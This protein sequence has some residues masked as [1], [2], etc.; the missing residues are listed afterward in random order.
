MDTILLSDILRRITIEKVRASLK[1]TIMY[2]YQDTESYSIDD[3]IAQYYELNGAICDRI[4]QRLT[5]NG[6]KPGECDLWKKSYIAYINRYQKDDANWCELLNYLQGREPTYSR[7]QV[8]AWACDQGDYVIVS[9]STIITDFKDKLLSGRTIVIVLEERKCVGIITVST[10]INADYTKTAKEIMATDITSFS[11]QESMSD[12]VKKHEQLSFDNFIVKK[13]N[14]DFMGVVSI[15]EI[16]DYCHGQ[17]PK[18]C[19]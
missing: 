7:E 5:G 6:C 8:G 15:Q 19:Q 1:Y 4:A 17:N 12:L 11:E 13:S 18:P 10:L 2:I 9:Q 3:R 16:V 14:G